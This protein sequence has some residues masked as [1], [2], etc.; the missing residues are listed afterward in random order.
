MCIRDRTNSS[1]DTGDA[2]TGII[3]NIA[4]GSNTLVLTAKGYETGDVSGH[5]AHTGPDGGC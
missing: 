3:A 5:H 2:N 1:F 4:V